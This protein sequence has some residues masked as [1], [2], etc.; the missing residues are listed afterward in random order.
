MVNVFKRHQSLLLKFIFRFLVNN[1]IDCKAEGDLCGGKAG[2]QCCENQHLKCQLDS[3]N[4]DANGK[5]VKTCHKAGEMCGGFTG[6][7]CCGEEGL[8][9]HLSAIYCDMSG[10]CV[11]TDA[12]I[13]F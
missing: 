1:E 6:I 12:N 10:T 13:F 11:K 8:K 7:Q 9:C 4:P 2:F 3:N 5:C